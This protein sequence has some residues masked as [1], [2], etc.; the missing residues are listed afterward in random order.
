MTIKE[1]GDDYR[2]ESEGGKHMGTYDSKKGADKRLKQIEHFKVLNK[3]RWM[4]M[5]KLVGPVT[6]T[7]AGLESKPR[8][9]RKKKKEDEED[10]LE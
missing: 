1:T 8:Y 10:E 6:S 9:G 2:V 5:L 4:K 3:G 7:T